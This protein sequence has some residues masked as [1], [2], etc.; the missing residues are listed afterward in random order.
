MFA[1][2]LVAMLRDEKLV[3]QPLRIVNK[4]AGASVSQPSIA[5]SR[6]GNAA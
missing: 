2:A 1:Q 3:A 6:S 4:T 5:Q